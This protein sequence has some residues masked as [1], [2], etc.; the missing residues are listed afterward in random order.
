MLNWTQCQVTGKYY[1][2]VGKTTYVIVRGYSF[3]LERV[4]GESIE[5]IGSFPYFKIAMKYAELIEL[6]KGVL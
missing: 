2:E 5:E 3:Y 6:D 1:S 4:I